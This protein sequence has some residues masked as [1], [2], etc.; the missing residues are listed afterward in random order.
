[1]PRFAANL[2]LLFTELPY[3]DRFQAAAQAGFKA[4]EILFPYD[5][6]AKETRRA[7][8][9]NGLELI[10]INA[11]P[12]N[13]T[14][15]QPGYAAIP[16]GQGRF[17]SDIRRVL[18]YSESLRPA[19]IHIMS[20]YASGPQALACFVDNLQW[21]ADVA[22]QQRFTIEPLN[23]VSQP[24]YFLNDYDLAVDILDRVDRPNVGLQYDSFHAQMIHGDALAIWNRFHDRV[25]H[26]QI[27]AAPDRSEPGRGSTDFPCLFKAMD[28]CGY[29]GW[30][31]AEYTPSTPRTIDSL[32]WM[33]G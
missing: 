2:S 11:P 16:G 29:A 1:M 21:A 13:Y 17:Q 28:S 15:G 6:A 24:K 12:P 25:A 26:A 3:L 10:L 33:H 7:L 14:G 19:L 18:R 30:V 32:G 27:G 4:V 22:P 9:A 5:L 23:P 31:S 20:G 8:L